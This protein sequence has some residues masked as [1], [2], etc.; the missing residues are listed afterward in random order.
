M[1][2]H[3]SG[4]GSG[5]CLVIPRRRPSGAI[6]ASTCG[7]DYESVTIEGFN[8][9]SGLGRGDADHPAVF[10]CMMEFAVCGE[11]F[12]QEPFWLPG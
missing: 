7:E 5:S 3:T 2:I 10:R 1:A 6:L 9:R 8:D 11:P 4:R 12:W